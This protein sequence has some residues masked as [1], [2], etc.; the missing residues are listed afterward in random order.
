MRDPQGLRDLPCRLHLLTSPSPLSPLLTRP[1]FSCLS[2][3]PDA[4]CPRTFAPV[5]PSAYPTRTR[6]RPG[7]LSGAGT[8][9]L[10][11]SVVPAP[12][13][14]PGSTRV[15]ATPT[16]PRG[17]LGPEPPRGDPSLHPLPGSSPPPPRCLSLVPAFPVPFRVR[18]IGEGFWG[19]APS[20]SDSARACAVKVSSGVHG[21]H[22]DGC[23][24][25]SAAALSDPGDRRGEHVPRV[26][27]P[28]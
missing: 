16:L 11:S 14:W 6:C 23:P 15:S 9:R 18:E 3:L 26:T 20:L 17:C 5:V 13:V 2:A 19:T 12:S 25:H 1:S 7:R 24:V 8:S 21:P 4:L 27:P 10:R 22:R 28:A